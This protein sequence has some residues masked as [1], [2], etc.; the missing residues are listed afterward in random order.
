MIAV[1]CGMGVSSNFG[2]PT[3]GTRALCPFRERGFATFL[4]SLY[5]TLQKGVL[6]SI[7]VTSTY[8]PVRNYLLTFQCAV[9]SAIAYQF[10]RYLGH[11]NYSIFDFLFSI[12][13]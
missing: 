1:G 2:A 10:V 12:F 9:I 4:P 8:Y 7:E 3:G 13:Y 5:T 11:D 6:F